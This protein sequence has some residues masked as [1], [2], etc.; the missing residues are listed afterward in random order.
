MKTNQISENKIIKEDE[1]LNGMDAGLSLINRHMEVVWVNKA[2]GC[3]FGPDEKVLG[4]KCYKCFERKN[5]VCEGCP[6]QKAF[7]D[8][9]PHTNAIRV[10]FTINGEKRYYKLTA[11]PMPNRQ[12]EV[13]EV[14]ESVIDITEKRQT[15]IKNRRRAAK[16]QKVNKAFKKMVHKRSEKLKVAN[17]ELKDIYELGN[18]LICSLDVDKVLQSIATIVPK[19]LKASGCI[20]RV[21]NESETELRVEAAYGVSSAFQEEARLMPMGEGVSGRVAKTRLII[22]VAD[23]FEEDH[24]KYYRE[25][26]REG[27]R[28]LIAAPIIFRNKILGVIIAFSREVRH[29]NGLESNLL[30]TFAAHAAI[31]L[32]NAIQHNKINLNY[33]NTMVTLVKAMEAKDHYTCGH[34]ERVTSYA[35]KIAKRS[36]LSKEDM[37]LLLYAGR[38]HDIGKIAIPDFILKKTGVLTPSE[39]AEIKAH[40]A[41]GIEMI[42]NLKF[43]KECFPLILHHHERYDGKGYPDRLKGEQ[44]PFLARI[45]SIADAFDAMTSER[46]YRKGLAINKA[47]EEIKKNSQTQFDPRLAESFLKMLEEQ[48]K[49]KLIKKAFVEEPINLAS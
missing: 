19:L 36:N 22:K 16:V 18:S 21:A 37:Q 10:G 38:L 27:M 12:N 7:K 45:L 28:S 34:S 43:L 33:Y 14:L 41:K 4:K 1:I 20:V 29:Y 35:L 46:P 5:A 13:E 48:P 2:M 26:S 32:N 30:S 11:T 31:A 44:I 47:I 6:V 25:C 3:W 40:P 42:I 24:L 15:D 9:A 49:A 8:K 39:K 17:E 23:I